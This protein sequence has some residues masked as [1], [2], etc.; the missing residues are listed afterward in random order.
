MRIN[1][2]KTQILFSL[3]FSPDNDENDKLTKKISARELNFINELCFQKKIEDYGITFLNG[4]KS[5]STNYNVFDQNTYTNNKISLRF[6]EDISI[7]LN[8]KILTM[9][10]FIKMCKHKNIKANVKLSLYAL[11]C[12]T[13]TNISISVRCKIREILILQTKDKILNMFQIDEKTII[14]MTKQL[15]FYQ[16]IQQAKRKR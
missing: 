16:N 6:N 9:N 14:K 3:I 5:K 11:I 10:E 12:T 1:L 15:T 4:Q 2:K 13:Q 8:N 7:K